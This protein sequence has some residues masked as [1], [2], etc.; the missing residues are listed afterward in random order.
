MTP[1]SHQL[2]GFNANSK[3]LTE[4]SGIMPSMETTEVVDVMFVNAIVVAK[5]KNF[6]SSSRSANI[7][8]DKM[9]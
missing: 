2:G 7:L 9:L 1:G 6:G 3:I 8:K 5:S 4:H